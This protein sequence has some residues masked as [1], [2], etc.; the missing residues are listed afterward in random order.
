MR[1]DNVAAM[2]RT[3]STGIVGHP[4]GNQAGHPSRLSEAHASIEICPAG[5]DTFVMISA[6]SVQPL[7]GSGPKSRNPPSST[8]RYAR[9]EQ[10][11]PLGAGEGRS[12]ATGR[13]ESPIGKEVE[14]RTWTDK[15]VHPTVDAHPNVRLRNSNDEVGAG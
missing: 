12:A 11:M 13:G 9:D 3:E 2:I 6:A 14:G 1:S 10:I 4:A 7:N 8:R 5:L 15:D